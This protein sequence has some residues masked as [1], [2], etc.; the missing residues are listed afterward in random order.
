MDVD[1]VARIAAFNRAHVEGWTPAAGRPIVTLC[2]GRPQPYSEAMCRLIHNTLV[3]VVAEMGV[4]LYDPRSNAFLMDPAITAE[5]LSAV[6]AAQAWIRRELGPHGVVIQP[7]KSAS[8]SLW[9]PETP[10]LMAMKPRLVE[11][12]ARE[13]WPLRVSSTVAW[14]N[15]DLAHVSKA[16]GIERMMAMMGLERG[17]ALGIG[18]T[19]G[20]MAIRQKVAFF[21]CPSNADPKLK[22]HADYV[23]E[24]PEIEGVLD[25]LDQLTS[26]R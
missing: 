3:P 2:S 10:R 6:A 9:H 1:R 19:M 18:D 7:G 25:I 12:F 16:T 8:I 5:H 4:W 17:H 24:L 14:I 11:T 26:R 21:A 15:C 13:G 20:D 23:S 22:D